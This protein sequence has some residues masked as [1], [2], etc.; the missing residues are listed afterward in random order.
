MDWGQFS[1]RATVI[2]DE[3]RIIVRKQL[4]LNSFVFDIDSF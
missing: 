2:L 4:Q 3:N 1:G